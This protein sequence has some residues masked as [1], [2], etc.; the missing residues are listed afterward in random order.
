MSGVLYLVPSPIGNLGDITQRAIDVLRGVDRVVAEDTRRSRQ[1]LSHLGITSKPLACINAHSSEK[2][3]SA[4]AEDLD[5]GVSVALLTD[6][7]MPSISDPGSALVRHA[8][9][10]G[11]TVVALPGPSA[12]T[13]AVA[14][15]GL[16]H[17]PFLFLGFL[18]RKGEKRRQLLDRIVRSEEPVVLFEAP[19]RMA[20]TLAELGSRLPERPVCVARELSKRFEEVRVLSGQ[21]WTQQ[22]EAWRGELTLVVGGASATESDTSVDDAELDVRILSALERGLPIKQATDELRPLTSLPRRELYRRILDLKQGLE[23]SARK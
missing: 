6:A 12:V 19:S 2:A 22:E 14:A 11:A 16:V 8:R 1:L 17:G 23:S 13:T 21:E 7:G 18:P 5:N 20:A 15:S 10:V 4:V 3:L 9:S